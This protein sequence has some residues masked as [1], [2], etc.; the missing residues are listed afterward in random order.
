VSPALTQPSITTASL[1]V[2]RSSGY[3]LASGES[4]R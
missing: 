4:G 3:I 2:L 1:N